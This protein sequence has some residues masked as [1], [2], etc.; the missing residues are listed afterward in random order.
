MK[1]NVMINIESDIYLNI[2]MLKS[3][4]EDIN[5]SQI[6]ESA[7]NNFLDI[8]EEEKTTSKLLEEQIKIRKQELNKLQM[9][10]FKNKKDEEQEEQEIKDQAKSFVQASKDARVLDFD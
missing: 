3:K 6:C 10:L 7:L 8:Q 2:Q 4:G 1:K 9:N 5:V